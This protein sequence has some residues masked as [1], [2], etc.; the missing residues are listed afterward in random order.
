MAD[1]AGLLTFVQELYGLS[2][3]QYDALNF[4]D[5]KDLVSQYQT[6]RAGCNCDVF[7][8]LTLSTNSH[9]IF[10]YQ[11]VSHTRFHFPLSPLHLPPIHLTNFPPPSSLSSFN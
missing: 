8:C 3:D 6:S 10:L 5:K 1:K 9:F 11:T 7:I 2:E 4:S